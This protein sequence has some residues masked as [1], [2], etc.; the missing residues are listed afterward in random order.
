MTWSLNQMQSLL[1][2]LVMLI[3][4]LWRFPGSDFRG[5]NYK[6]VAM[7]MQHV[8]VSK[9]LNPGTHACTA[10][11]FTLG[12]SSQP[13]YFTYTKSSWYVLPNHKDDSDIMLKSN[14]DGIHPS[15]KRTECQHAWFNPGKP[16]RSRYH[17]CFLSKFFQKVFLTTLCLV[18]G[19]Q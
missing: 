15:S 17:D 19:T 1:I 14:H 8:W 7:P 12:P 13:S 4:L 16:L 10:S 5:Q 2:W 9:N 11:S 6:S 18:K 3:S